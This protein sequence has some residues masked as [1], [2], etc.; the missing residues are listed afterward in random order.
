MRI[1]LVQFLGCEIISLFAHHD[2]DGLHVGVVHPR[3]AISAN[4][5]VSHCVNCCH[6]KTL[7]RDSKL[8]KADP[9]A[10]MPA[11]PIPLCRNQPTGPFIPPQKSA[12]RQHALKTSLLP[13]P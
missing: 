8:F 2:F 6:P 5:D 7:A 1:L 9:A 3:R 11:A 13:S 10:S 12:S 4:P